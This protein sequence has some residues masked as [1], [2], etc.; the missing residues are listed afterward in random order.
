MRLGIDIGGTGVK[1]AM[2]D[3]GVVISE[4][5]SDSYARP[6]T[7]TLVL[8][9]GVACQR[10]GPGLPLAG[11]LG[12]GLS[13]P[14]MLDEGRGEVTASI[15]VPGLV[16]ISLCELLT[17]AL[18]V[19]P[20][21]LQYFTDAHA[22]VLDLLATDPCRLGGR[23]LAISLGT[24]V[25]MCVL[26]DGKALLV[27]GRSSGHLGQMDV[28]IHEPGREPPVGPD[29]GRGGLEAYIG[30][31]ALVRRLGCTPETLGSKLCQDMVPLV[32]LVRAIRIAHAVYR[33]QHVRLLGGI[34][35]QLSSFL[36][37]MREE[38]SRDLTSLA[39][40]GWTLACGFTRFHAARGAA[41]D[42]GEMYR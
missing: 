13:V 34:G 36:E 19:V 22:A 30:L 33:P 27:S 15:N 20:P 21:P 14:G 29:G 11:L 9:I 24:G 1:V 42:I 25:G 35:I 7:E 2:V 10:L 6:D 28:S 23:V 37:F 5:A 31:P 39:R 12:I 38:I 32:A 4:A 16:G 8:A 40:P 17:R 26:D 18:G 3:R 41:R